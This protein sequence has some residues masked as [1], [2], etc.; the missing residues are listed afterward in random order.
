MRPTAGSRNRPSSPS[1]TPAG[2]P[3]GLIDPAALFKSEYDAYN[4]AGVWP[5]GAPAYGEYFDAAP[6]KDAYGPDGK[7]VW[8]G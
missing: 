6:A 5:K 2:T 7:V 4:T 8:P 3:V 1:R